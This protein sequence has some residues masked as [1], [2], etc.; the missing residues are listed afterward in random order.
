[1]NVRRL[2]VFAISK[3]KEHILLQTCLRN[4]G[5]LKQNKL[6]Y[7]LDHRAQY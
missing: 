6:P 4:P 2:F 7:F 1:M 5:F 3:K